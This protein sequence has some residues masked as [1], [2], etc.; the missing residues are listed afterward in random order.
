M[1][2]IVEP[3]VAGILSLIGLDTGRVHLAFAQ[4]HINAVD[5][6]ADYTAAGIDVGL[7][8]STRR[9]H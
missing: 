1:R 4:V 9:S 8:L 7:S 3:P 5:C 2:S 6:R